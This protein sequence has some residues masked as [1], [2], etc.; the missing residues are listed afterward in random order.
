M[1]KRTPIEVF[2]PTAGVYEASTVRQCKTTKRG[3]PECDS[4]TE[5]TN[6]KPP[7]LAFSEQAENL[8]SELPPGSS[9]FTKLTTGQTE[10]PHLI[11]QQSQQP[12]QKSTWQS[13]TKLTTHHLEEF[14]KEILPTSVQVQLAQP[15][16]KDSIN[17]SFYAEKSLCHVLLPLF[18]SGFLSR[19]A[20]KALEKASPRARQLQ[21][22]RKKYEPIDFR[23]LQGFQPDWE[24]TETIRQ[25]WK[26]MTTACALYY[27]GDMAT[28]VRYIGGP[29]V[30]AHIDT[31][32][33]LEKL[34]PVLTS[35]VYDDVH[36]LLVIGAPALC[37]A[38]ASKQNFEAYLQYGNHKSANENPTVFEK[39]IVKQSK[40]GLTLILDPA[41]V[42]FTLNTHLTPQG[43]VDILHHR[44]K[45]RPVSDSS[46]RPWPGAFAINDWT[47]KA[48]E[49]KLHF[50]DSFQQFCIWMW[51]LAISYPNHDRYTG[52]D[53]VQC[54]FPRVKYNP[55]LV[56]MHS[57]LSHDTLIMHTGLTFGDNTS[58]SSWEP[59]ARARQ[60]LAQK[61][62]HEE[63]IIER[64]AP[65]MPN[66]TF[67]QPAT[68]EERKAF[69]VAVPDSKNKGVFDKN[70]N[71]LSPRYNHHVDDNMYGDIPDLI[72]RSAAASV[73]SLY[74]IMGY[75]DGRIPD[76]I[77]W[78]KFGSAYGHIRRVVGWDFNTRSLT[79]TLPDDKRTS[80]V[81][82]LDEWK[83]KSH[84]TIVE[85]AMLHG[86]LADASR[87]NRQGRTLFFAFQNAL[88]RAIQL[89]FNQVRGYYSRQGK[90]NK[91]KA[92]LPKHLHH[93]ID[94]MIARDMAALLWSKKSKIQISESVAA[95]IKYLHSLLADKTYLWQMNIGHVIP[96]DAQFTSF[97]D[98]CLV[99]GGAYCHE[100]QFWFDVHWSAKTREGIEQNHIHINVMEFIIV[101]LQL[102]ATITQLEETTML[103]QI[104]QA[105]PDGIPA[106]AKLLIRT[107]NSP[108]QN[109]AHKVSAKSEK[110]Q[111]MVRIYAALLERTS[112]TV[113]CTHVS[114][115]KNDLADFIS[116]PPTNL[117]SPAMRHKQIF[118][119]EPKLKLYRYFR[120]APELLSSLASKLSS[121]Q[122][123]ETIQL[124]KQLGQFEAGDCITSSFV[125]L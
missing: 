90:Q 100:L 120:P 22:L 65:Y 10:I 30:N 47:S 14:A 53:D 24:S 15:F 83:Q 113:A 115:V 66:I 91:F 88:R 125:I 51:N 79:F 67:E 87:A 16:G 107:D 94:A 112:I 46:F 8:E 29:H 69:A 13:A 103:P 96:R 50:A 55:N 95:E 20:I 56:A 71:R 122:W 27:N 41:L 124:P 17:Q 48:N 37:N 123:S 108:S 121:E 38:K 18:K 3:I 58:P 105:F 7:K 101:I 49:P 99:G 73:I 31:R 92:Q 39:T 23:P 114:G 54:A 109:W 19:R 102:A 61:L 93:R 6:N 64:A 32:A 57:A 97:G 21:Q 117:P 106:L 84:C 118:E 74:E 35:D 25:D 33:V 9:E 5:K 34:K 80:I 75:P 63:D 52:D 86:T 43:L 2:R 1:P 72:P 26:D 42:H 28:V 76:P 59:F 36:R 68:P 77:S 111:H 116:R 78:E 45:P 81:A 119:K 12:Q 62:W 70:G 85:A 44:R 104:A 98:A 82:L 40:R 110:G 60:Q 4:Q 89:R 11:S